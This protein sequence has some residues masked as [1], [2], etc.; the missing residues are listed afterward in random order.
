MGEHAPRG[1]LA[2]VQRARLLAATVGAIEEHGY[3]Q[4]TVAQITARSR[5]SRRTFYEIFEDRE[6]CLMAV[7]EDV[8]AMLERELAAIDLQRLPWRERVS[9]GL[10]AILAFLDREP[11]L[12]RVCVVQTLHGGPR[13]LE[14]RDQLLARLACVIDEGR[15]QGSQARERTTV[16]AEGLVNA[17][18]GI[19]YARLLRGERRPLVT[20]RGELMSL[21]VLPYL[22]PAAARRELLRPLPSAAARRRRHPSARTLCESDPLEGLPMRLTYRTA[23]VLQVIAAR[24]GISNRAA[25]QRAGIADQGQMSKLLARLARLGLIANDGARRGN[26]E[27]NAWTLTP[28][29]CRVAQR[30]R[31]GDGPRGE[32]V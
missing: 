24:P 28:L 11:A 5:I 6:A 32:G 23:C 10:D 18:L 19:V 26:G 20:L 21:I 8:V 12:A 15:K 14:Q 17:T 16:T 29:G 1:R 9:G 3:A 31:V 2:E 25:S 30:L 4:T 13:A 7:V 27:A 22:G